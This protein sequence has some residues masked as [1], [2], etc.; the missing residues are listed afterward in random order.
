MKVLF[1]LSTSMPKKNMEFFLLPRAE[2]YTG[3][4]KKS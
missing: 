4:G 3:R 1:K 2:V